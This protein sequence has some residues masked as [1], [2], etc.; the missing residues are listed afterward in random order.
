MSRT[1][2][3]SKWEAGLGIHQQTEGPT[4]PSCS[5]SSESSVLNGEGLSALRPQPSQSSLPGTQSAF[6]FSSQLPA[7]ALSFPFSQPNCG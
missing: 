7:P 2:R 6:L 4:V 3:L 1:S 5:L